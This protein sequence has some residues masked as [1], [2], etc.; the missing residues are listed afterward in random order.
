M[1]PLPPTDAAPHDDVGMS[2]GRRLRAAREA[3][4]L[5]LDALALMLKVPTRQ[6]EALENDQYEAFSG[7]AFVRATAQTLC[8]HLGLDPVPVLAGLPQTA[9]SMTVR[10]S[11]TVSLSPHAWPRRPSPRPGL[12][13]RV[14]GLA[15][16]M[17]LVS[18]VLIW[19][20]DAV[21]LPELTS[22][23]TSPATAAEEFVAPASA[24]ASD[25]PVMVSTAPTSAPTWVPSTA[26]VTPVASVPLSTASTP[27]TPATAARPPEGLQIAASGETWLEVRD[28]RGQVLVNR[29]LQAGQ[30]QS[31]SSGRGSS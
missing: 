25:A 17:L 29:L 27:A 12:S 11:A 9:A 30:V 3:R 4:G 2:P 24:M 20:P 8:R 13:R 6:L 10:S 18:V 1:N 31:S 22:A 19:W 16:L 21:R 5:R 28:A 23:K 26:V 7:P 15:G 14:L